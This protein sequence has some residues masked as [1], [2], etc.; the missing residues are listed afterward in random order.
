MTDDRTA[1]ARPTLAMAVAGFVALALV[2]AVGGAAATLLARSGGLLDDT[3]DLAVRSRTVASGK[4]FGRRMNDDWIALRFLA[5]IAGDTDPARLRATMEGMRGDGRRIS[6]IGFADVGGTVVEATGGL[7][8]GADVGARPWFRNGL[9]GDFAGD[10]HEAVLLAEALRPEGGDPLSF[11]DLATPVRDAQ[12]D[13]IG[14]VGMHVDAAWVARTL[15]ET[16]SLLTLD[17]FLLDGAGNVVMAPEGVAADG[18]GG[19]VIGAA[20]T[21]SVSSGRE[22]WPDGRTYFTATVPDIQYGDLPNFG[23]RL[24]GRIEAA[25]YR[26]GFVQLRTALLVATAVAVVI[27]ALATL[28]F[29][30][31]FVRPIAILSRQAVRIGSGGEVY[32]YETATTAEADRLSGALARLQGRTSGRVTRSDTLRG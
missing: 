29:V 27:F 11:V 3:L 5:G 18:A 9:Q 10:V 20:R 6:W 17:L 4:L 16:G 13:V 12:G 28:L 32:P 21:A 19:Q 8:V 1:R 2:L 15:Q 26:P 24:A 31:I 30:R 22:V 14:V 23:W 25:A 7:L